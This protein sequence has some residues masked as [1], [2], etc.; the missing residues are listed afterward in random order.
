MRVQITKLPLGKAAYGKQV[1]GSLSLTPAGLND[2]SYSKSNK[3]QYRGTKNTI[4][5]VPRDKAN[6]EAEGGETAFGPISGQSIPD[7]LVIKGKR[8]SAGGVPLN[9]PD[10]TFIFSDTA[11]L[12]INDPAI[13]AMFNL[14]PKKGGYT[15]ANIAKPYNINKYKGILLD[16][17]SSKLERDTAIIMIKNYI[18]KLGALAIVQESMKGFPQG[19][20]EMAKPYMEANG[21]TEEDLIPEL[22][23]QAQAMSKIVDQGQNPQSP[24]GMDPQQM[25]DP[26]AEQM[27]PGQEPMADGQ[28]PSYP[29][30]MPSGAPVA[31]PENMQ[32]MQQSGPPPQQMN[33]QQMNPQEMMFRG[34]MRGLR[35]ANQGMQQP[36]EEEMMMMEEQAQ[37]QQGGQD[38]QMQQVMQQVAQALEKG[39]EPEK[40]TVELLQNQIAPQEILQIFVELGLPKDQ[41]QQLI[42]DVMQQMQGGQ[43]PRQMQ[44]APMA[45][46]G[47]SMGGYD[48]PFYDYNE[49]A[50]GGVP[51]FEGPGN[52]QVNGGGGGGNGTISSSSSS[53][54]NPIV[55]KTR[56]TD[57]YNTSGKVT[58]D[59]VAGRTYTDLGVDGVRGWGQETINEKN[60]AYQEGQGSYSGTN[61]QYIQD[62]CK[63]LKTGNLKGVSAKYAIDVLKV[64][65]PTHAKRAEWELIL[66]GCEQVDKTIET[67]FVKDG[68]GDC[69]CKKADGSI[70]KDAQGNTK[71][72]PMVDGV[73]Q[74]NDP[75]CSETPE[76]LL[77][78]CVDPVTGEVKEFPI[79]KIEECVCEGN[80]K[81]KVVR[82]SQ[83]HWSVPATKNVIRN[84]IMDVNPAPSNQ[85]VTPTAQ[86][87]GAYEEY[88]TKTDQALAAV[89]NASNAI[90]TGTSGSSGKK[91]SRIKDLIGKG[92]RGA[93][94]A[95]AGVQSRNVDR[96]RETNTQ[97]ATI[98]NRNMELRGN[99][100]N[101]ALAMQKGDKDART[102]NV[103]KRRFNTIGASMEADKE[104]AAR[105]QMNVTTP[106]YAS[107]YDYG[108]I[109]PTGVEKP[110][111][112][113]NGATMEDRIQYYIKKTGDYDKAFDMAYKEARLN[114]TTKKGGELTFKKGGYYL[115][116]SA[117]PFFY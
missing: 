53:S 117:Y 94:D 30:E 82:G 81:G 63:R 5:A 114:K 72:A 50:Y 23:E 39:V 77:C 16:P 3:E 95:V 42:V 66:Q 74:E 115:G 69:L 103:N 35:R 24:Q 55:D 65:L 41:V 107:E 100:F 67:Q 31:S 17:D 9:L 92:L 110:F 90:M 10:D 96:Q 6:L 46:Y 58:S 32:Q 108:F 2:L 36:S 12:K 49:M 25:P 22:K 84:A 112:G 93:M 97:R 76:E 40:L 52:S 28:D 18:I 70:W 98:D 43:D 56:L 26:N 88:Q 33:P 51:K 14:T 99:I 113:A 8:H 27:A 29:E 19:I 15:P 80:A 111:T 68:T 44:Q 83:P 57:A 60:I 7:H 54:S 71:K 20:P 59:A 13:L 105:Q 116:E 102:G 38:M 86:I 37:Q 1:D 79:T 62:I 73:C 89:G 85:V 34:G 48:M 11:S 104:M 47:R 78:R 45:E 64:I 109:E 91:Q 106:Q 21:I 75:S 61:D 101:N 87:E 4:S